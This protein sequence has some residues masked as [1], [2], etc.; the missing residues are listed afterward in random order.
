MNEQLITEGQSFYWIL[1]SL[2]IALLLFV[3]FKYY[4]IPEWKAKKEK[5]EISEN[6]LIK[7]FIEK[8]RKIKNKI[9]SCENQWQLDTLA[10]DISKFQREFTMTLDR[11]KVEQEVDE[12]IEAWYEKE[13]ELSA[14]SPAIAT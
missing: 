9:L 10:Y 3:F 4:L 11:V 13:A 1:L 2:P 14:S 8:T 6:D 12:L 7:Q 5:V